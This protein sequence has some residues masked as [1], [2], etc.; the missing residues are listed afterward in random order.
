MKMTPS[1]PVSPDALEKDLETLAPLVQEA[2]SRVGEPSPRV[3]RAIHNE[4]VA[5]LSARNRRRRFIPLFRTLAAAATLTLL[6]GGAIQAHI[7]RVEIS[8]A[9]DVGHL[10]N[11]GAT[12]SPSGT[13]EASS[14]LANRLLSIQGLDEDDFFFDDILFTSEEEEVLWL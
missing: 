6:L 11:L 8:H 3:L 12:H 1:T 10:L 4:A 5:Y 7:A 14:E 2:F 9:R 13:A